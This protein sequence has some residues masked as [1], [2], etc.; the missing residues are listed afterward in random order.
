MK[1]KIGALLSASDDYTPGV[2]ADGPLFPGHEAP[3][4]NHEVMSS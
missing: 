4:G 2:F 1:F 3:V